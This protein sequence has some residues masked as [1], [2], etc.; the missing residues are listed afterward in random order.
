[1]KSPAVFLCAL[2]F[3]T[4]A[5][6]ADEVEPPVYRE[7]SFLGC[8]EPSPSSSDPVAG[9]SLVELLENEYWLAYLSACI[10]VYLV[11]D[12]VTPRAEAH[13]SD[14]PYDT[15]FARPEI[16]TL[17]FDRFRVWLEQNFPGDAA[18][19]LATFAYWRSNTYG[20][21]ETAWLGPAPENS[22]TDPLPGY[23]G[24]NDGLGWSPE[25]LS[26]SEPIE[27]PSAVPA[28]METPPTASVD[29]FAGLSLFELFEDPDW[30]WYL[31]TC[32]DLYLVQADTVLSEDAYES[33]YAFFGAPAVQAL[34]PGEIAVWLYENFPMDAANLAVTFDHWRSRAAIPA[35]DPAANE[36]VLDFSAD[37]NNQPN[38]I[39]LP[40]E[41]PCQCGLDATTALG[42]TLDWPNRDPIIENG[43]IN[44]YGYVGN[45]PISYVDPY[46]LAV[47]DWYDPHTYWNEGFAEGWSKGGQGVIN[48]FTGGLFWPEYGL[49]YDTFDKQWKDLGTEGTK[50]DLAFKF[51]NNGGRLAVGCLAGAGGAM[52][53]ESA[54]LIDTSVQANNMFRIMS[55]PLERGLR[56]DKPHHGKWYHWHWWK[57]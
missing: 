38:Q 46:G 11:S 14:L 56:L 10:E 3:I 54:G 26:P 55:K 1:M 19:L 42:T 5:V 24:E 17:D 4:G 23:T 8:T 12:G 7:D 22:D 25:A 49:F 16:Q 9:L 31:A 18:D 20:P 39:A 52:A 48:A 41:A 33:P 2:L 28:E 29:P 40:A 50:D 45:N 13:E 47:G 6:W 37:V 51:G 43:G 36:Q 35:I 15:Y 21:D 57:W 30:V 53:A 32:V 27:A 34:V 44:L